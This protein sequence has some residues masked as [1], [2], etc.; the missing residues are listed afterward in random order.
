MPISGKSQA[1]PECKRLCNGLAEEDGEEAKPALKRKKAPAAGKRKNG[2][3]TDAAPTS[4]ERSKG[5]AADKSKAPKKRAKPSAA[6]K[7]KPGMK[8]ARTRKSRT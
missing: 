1:F 5:S 6:D 3:D 4:V 8:N 7:S 2:A